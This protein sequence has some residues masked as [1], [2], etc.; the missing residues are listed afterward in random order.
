MKSKLSMKLL[1]IVVTIAT[2][3]S[4]LV[5]LTAAPVS[6][7]AGT[8]GYSQIA[9]PSE[10][11]NVLVPGAQIT[12]IAASINGGVVF[13]YDGTIGNPTSG[14][15]YEST[16]GGVT[17]AAP[18]VFPTGATEMAISPKF[19]TDNTLVL[20]TPTAVY[21]SAD[22][23]ATY[24][25]LNIALGGGTVTSV[26]VGYYYSGNVLSVLVGLTGSGLASNVLL[27]NLNQGTATALGTMTSNVWDVKFSPN[28]VNDAEIVCVFDN[29]GS[30][31]I[32]SIFG[33]LGWNESSYPALQ[34]ILSAGVTGVKL[35]LP[36]NYRGN[37]GATFLMAVNGGA[38]HGIY[39]VTG[40]HA[41]A[42]SYNA[43]A[44]YVGDIYS[45]AVTDS[46]AKVY[47]GLA[48][49]GTVEYST[50]I[51]DTTP[52]WTGVNNLTGTLNASVVVRGATVFCGTGGPDGALN[53]STD[54]TNFVQTAMIDIG[55]VPS[56]A[57]AGLKVADNNNM[58]LLMSNAGETYLF[59]TTTG[60]TAWERTQTIASP[61]VYLAISRAFAT[62]KT[63]A[64]GMAGNT[65]AEMST[66]GGLT[67]STFNTGA[68]T[69]AFAVGTG[70]VMYTGGDAGNFYQIG[71]LVQ[72]YRP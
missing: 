39:S 59:K 66:D 71:Q 11:N 25:A 30:L 69:T 1:G 37:T 64:Y 23:G 5:G 51:A 38:L 53:V 34:T 65:T 41:V 8:L 49:G 54:G 48:T 67:W 4:L 32:G 70:G 36:T 10:V 16:D 44:K 58:F 50:D 2:L 27:V 13:A 35:A 7:A 55:A 56:L 19:S 43:T 47:F 20:A 61:T 18:V 9:T 46:L 12:L 68:P 21:R 14:N 24:Y 62:D 45:I 6:A 60:G 72:C 17:F 40:R 42:G 28:H 26:D 15:L 31:W 57:L 52:T 3:A 63:V 33:N 29:L 22:G